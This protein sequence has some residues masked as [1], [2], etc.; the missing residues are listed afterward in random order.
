MGDESMTARL[1]AVALA[2]ISD[3]GG[4]LVEFD[5]E[6]R[7]ALL[8]AI[9]HLRS[10]IAARESELLSL[11]HADRNDI[12]AGARDLIQLNQQVANVGHG[13]A[14]RRAARSAWTTE[15][16]TLREALAHG[17]LPVGHV[18]EICLL[19][20]RLEPEHHPAL[21]AEIDTLITDIAPLT[22]VQARKHL[23]AFE[24]SLDTDD[25]RSRLERQRR[26]NCVRLP[27]RPDGCLGITGQL[28][29]VSGEVLRN[30]IDA[31][32]T[33]M[34]RAE[35]RGRADGAPP[36]SVLTNDRRRANALVDLVRAG[37]A[38]GPGGPGRAEVIVLIDHE[39]LLAQLSR[40]PITQLGSGEPI[41]AAE[42]R[43][44][45]CDAGLIPAVLGGRSQPLDVGRTG[46]LATPAQRIALRAA[47]ETCCITGCDVPFDH[48]EIHHI[49]WW[50]HGGG[51]DLDN[52]APVCSKHH[53]LVHDHR[54]IL[55]LDADRIGHLHH[56][57]D[58]E[59]LQTPQEPPLPHPSR[60]NVTTTPRRRRS[61]A[62][63]PGRPA[64]MPP[65]EH[66]RPTRC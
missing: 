3:L 62:S 1:M 16:P 30:A 37:A 58:V 28:D 36:D 17:E 12:D 63:G 65:P 14:R 59:I 6:D 60:R 23:K 46:R 35:G 10:W 40:S 33:R 64:A 4:D 32:V 44:L 47:H 66:L 48:C 8:G 55:T 24:H 61:Q 49:S 18:D 52:L 34:W 54:W 5:G 45:A 39:T 21:R 13:E 43:R 19:G 31:R 41:P 42:A 29:P 50:R 15:L 22:P 51:T 56:R 7:V 2:T 11:V 38:A 57:S 26:E 53:H 27:K 25:G 9:E 20:E